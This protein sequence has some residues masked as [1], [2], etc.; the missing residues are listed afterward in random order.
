[1][2]DFEAGQAEDLAGDAVEGDVKPPDRKSRASVV[3]KEG[4]DTKTSTNQVTGPSNSDQS[5]HTSMRL[6]ERQPVSHYA[7]D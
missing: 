5:S 6:S 4:C 7:E 2:G 3:S 1:M